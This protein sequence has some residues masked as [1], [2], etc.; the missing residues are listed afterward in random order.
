MVKRMC[1]TVGNAVTDAFVTLLVTPP[2]CNAAP[3]PTRPDP[4][5]VTSVCKRVGHFAIPTHLAPA[6]QC[7][8]KP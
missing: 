1:N 5:V 4:L 3:D 6:P 7:E 8:A 2:L